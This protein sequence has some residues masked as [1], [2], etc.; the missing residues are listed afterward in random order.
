MDMATYGLINENENYRGF[1]IS[2]Q[3][4]PLTGAKWTANVASESPHLLNLMGRN[5]SEVIDSRTRNE[6]LA[7]AKKYIDGLFA[8]MRPD[9]PGAA[10]ATVRDLFLEA[11]SKKANDV[12]WP[13]IRE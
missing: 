13:E 3:E 1:T 12:P 8:R 2:W 11:L 6:M 4:P 9:V 5:G 10:T 7:E